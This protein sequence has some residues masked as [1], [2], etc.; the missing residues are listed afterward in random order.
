MVL[1]RGY[2]DSQI[3]FILTLVGY[4][5]GLGNVWRFPYLCY[6]YGGGQLSSVKSP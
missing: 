1:Q 6:Q 4:C 2:W 5:I 3:Q